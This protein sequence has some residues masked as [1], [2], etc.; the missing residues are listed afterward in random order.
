M[1]HAIRRLS[2]VEHFPSGEPDRG[3]VPVYVR[4]PDSSFSG[5]RLSWRPLSCPALASSQLA[6]ALWCLPIW[7]MQC[8]SFSAPPHER[9]LAAPATDVLLGRLV[10]SPYGYVISAPRSGRGRSLTVIVSANSVTTACAKV[11]TFIFLYFRPE[12]IP[13]LPRLTLV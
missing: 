2:S 4:G 9:C 3:I 13:V 6:P 5:P 12:Q 8:P 7:Q 11:P 10:E 1:R